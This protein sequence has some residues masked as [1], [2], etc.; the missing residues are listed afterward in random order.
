MTKKRKDTEGDFSEQITFRLTKEMKERIE[1]AASENQMT[2]A[3]WVR[4]VC[5]SELDKPQSWEEQISVHDILIHQNTAE[6][7]KLN[8]LCKVLELRINRIDELFEREFSHR[9]TK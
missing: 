6:I 5:A 8:N 2:P 7:G 3:A 9:G 1:F 4:R